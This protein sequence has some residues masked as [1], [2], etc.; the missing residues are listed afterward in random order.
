[1]STLKNLSIIVQ[2]EP[3]DVGSEIAAVTAGDSAGAVA[4]F[5]GIVRGGSDGKRLRSMSL[6]HYAGMTERELE[7][8]AATASERFGLNAVTVIH[9]IGEL[10]PGEQIVLVVTAAPHRHAAFDGCAF[11][12]DYLKTSAPFWKKETA[13]DGTGTW[14]D[15]RV[16]DNDAIARWDR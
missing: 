11:I 14:V 13:I 10:N 9:R 1:M 3:F 6:E 7:R 15:A 8:I 5:T 2:T 16:T 4:S 12:M